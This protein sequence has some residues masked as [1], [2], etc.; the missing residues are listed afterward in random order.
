MLAMVC[1]FFTILVQNDMSIVCHLALRLHK[2]CC[3]QKAASAAFRCYSDCR[4]I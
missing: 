3:E 2:N 1:L 4:P